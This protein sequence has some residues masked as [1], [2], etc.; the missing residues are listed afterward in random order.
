MR[1]RD[2]VLRAPGT[3]ISSRT[4]GLVLG[5]VALLAAILVITAQS[6]LPKQ[7]I[8]NRR[9]TRW[10]VYEPAG[11]AVLADAVTGRVVLQLD[12]VEA[13]R[14]MVALQGDA[15]A[16]L[17]DRTA[18]QAITID[19]ENVRLDT[20]RAVQS[21]V[22]ES[23]EL[24]TGVGVDG[25]VAVSAS[26]GGGVLVPPTGAVRP[27][28]LPDGSRVTEVAAD[29]SV[30]TVDQSLSVVH[31]QG[32]TT[33]V[34][35]SGADATGTANID[36]TTVGADAVV[37][38]RDESSI[39]WLPSGTT[40]QLPSGPTGID[41]VLQQPGVDAPCVWVARVDQLLCVGRDGVDDSVQLDGITID[42][43]DRL[44][45]ADGGALLLRGSGEVV[46]IRL[47][48]GTAETVPFSWTDGGERLLASDET[49]AWL[50]DPAGKTTLVV[51]AS[52]LRRITK[53]DDSA[54]VFD[55]DG[56]P[57]LTDQAEEET[58]GDGAQ[59]TATEFDSG[60]IQP[61]DDGVSEPPVA[62]PDS[63]SARQGVEV[64]V[65]A[66]ANDY[67]PDGQAVVI[68][69]VI[70]P[71]RG[72][73][74]ILDS[75]TLV[76]TP[77]SDFVG[78]E[79]FEYTIADPD[80]MTASADVSVEM[81]SADAPNRPPVARADRASTAFGRAVVVDVLRNDFDAE[82]T[83]LSVASITPPPADVGRVERVVLTD[84][85]VAL[86]FIPAASFQD[87]T[88]VFSY[89]A[90]DTD[91]GK[92]APADVAVTVGAAGAANSPPVAVDDAVRARP[93]QSATI[94]VLAN[95]VDPDN[96]TL[97]IE[98]AELVDPRQ[99]Q[100]VI[101]GQNL[102]FVARP[103]AGRTV[104]ID[105]T[106][107]DGEGETDDGEVFVRVLPGTAENEPPV[108]FPDQVTTSSTTIF[109]PTRN[110]HDPDNDRLTLVEVGQPI[111]G[112]TAQVLS[113]N[114]VAFAPASG[115]TGTFRFSY[116]ITDGHGHEAIGQIAVVVSASRLPD[117]PHA[118]DDVAETTSDNPVTV[119]VLANDSDPSGDQLVLDGRPS[120]QYGTC[121]VNGDETITYAPPAGEVGTFRFTYRVRNSVGAT[122]TATVIVQVRK[123]SVVN[124]PPI[125]I[126]DV[127][128][129]VRGAPTT[130]DVLA[131]DRDEHPTTLVLTGVGETPAGEVAVAGR[132]VRFT[133]NA[134]GPT[135][136]TFQYEVE[137]EDGAS[138]FGS[139]TVSIRA[140]SNNPPVAV[141]DVRSV[142]LGASP[143]DVDVVDNDSTENGTNDT[144]KLSGN[145]VVE[146][147]SG[148][149]ARVGSRSLRIT[150]AAGYVG[151]VRVRYEIVDA[152]GLRAT[153]HYTLTVT[154]P[155]NQAPVAHD[156]ARETNANTPLSIQV[157]QND[158]DADG[159]PLTVEI[160][161]GPSSSQGAVSVQGD[162]RTV[163][164]VPAPD[165]AGIA[166]FSYVAV[167]GTGKRSNV[168]S[169]T[170]NVI[171]CAQG[172]PVAPDRPF[173]FTPYD[174]PLEIGLLAPG[175][176]DFGLEILDVANG[177][178][179]PTGG[180]RVVYT[181]TPGLNDGGSFRYRVINSCGTARTGRVEIDV[182][183]VPRFTG[184]SFQALQGQPLSLPVSLFAA[185]HEGLIITSVE[186]GSSATGTG[187]AAVTFQSSTLGPQTVSV[188]VA[189]PGGL[190]ARG[191]IGINVIPVP[192]SPPTAERQD[193]TMPP[194]G[195]TTVR[196][197]ERVSD[198]GPV[199]ALRVEIVRSSV[200][201][202]N[203]G[204]ISAEVAADGQTVL[205]T[206][207]PDANGWGTL[208]YRVR[209]D[210]DQPSNIAE[211][212]VKVNNAPTSQTDSVTVAPGSSGS[213]TVTGLDPD[214]NPVVI[215]SVTSGSP[216]V[217][218]T[219]AGDL[220]IAYTVA[221]EAT[222][223][224]TITYRLTD[225]LSSST[226][227]TLIL[228][229]A[230]G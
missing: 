98:S 55:I 164:F 89:I 147:G 97:A 27:I 202:S 92:S 128:N 135:T 101:D 197:I 209:D 52:G 105:Y 42:R 125:A 114:R 15:G 4:A 33:E 196:V 216:T 221:P 214:G 32:A 40:V 146:S 76:F 36:L 64:A 143:P 7:L 41:A 157:L 107:T 190:S 215:S 167:D 140:P 119:D 130:I 113:D 14:D 26:E 178:V 158:D 136:A 69:E 121:R 175:Q 24:I 200:A 96:D 116:T 80:G 67:D 56:K 19:E 211:L 29:G 21:L 139:V 203:R 149:V 51:T 11:R 45:V 9:G 160:V 154:P 169:V 75:S 46:H 177:Q 13:G 112:G 111:G 204:E 39:R 3:G 86:K 66:T 100:L 194:G 162:Q 25:A 163:R 227:G 186:P 68:D 122:A 110:D 93:G 199:S 74:S 1:R 198:D 179:T 57:V 151:D 131:N 82:R 79:S 134:T 230:S 201:L 102:L 195:P 123:P 218:A 10:L 30:W 31:Q 132:S 60:P 47:D 174:T 155:A 72:R 54:P 88:A 133:P 120:C 182:N 65:V 193:W 217:G 49:G 70:Q 206:S 78:T 173:E 81:I 223:A 144:L 73:V 53:V 77:P 87:D 166:S 183:Q 187:T 83:Q 165:F 35:S 28:D 17:I 226:D 208:T 213:F 148:T 180:G 5:A 22:S 61:D 16:Y 91:D 109:D 124:R 159:D 229:I 189:D 117:A 156:D 142:V 43:N 228:Q 95:D 85:R 188:T 63:A 212:V 115:K 126:E 48:S 103:T 225:T 153:G 207:T 99:G 170:V 205:V 210:A 106:V 185:D 138:A 44:A 192:N 168:A 191:T 220:T 71:A 37:L 161:A 50:D 129:A 152:A 181:P 59:E 12:A 94:P 104:L 219:K 90:A 38:D 6:G 34:Y 20:G 18:G 176:V 62:R 184:G 145:P 141:D 58:E 2:G 23:G 108:T 150:P 171:A 137:D 118:T 8:E 224:A 222:G 84:G 127:A 172:L